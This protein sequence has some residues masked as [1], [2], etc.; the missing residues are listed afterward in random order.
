MSVL[1]N[2]TPPPGFCE[3]VRGICESRAWF[4]ALVKPV[5]PNPL[6]SLQS[7]FLQ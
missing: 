4:L 6:R 7:T 1:D 5:Q 3:T 2:F